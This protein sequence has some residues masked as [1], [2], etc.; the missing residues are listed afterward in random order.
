MW[1]SIRFFP[2]DYTNMVLAPCHKG[3]QGKSG[4][5]T[6]ETSKKME[7]NASQS[8]IAES[9]LTSDDLDIWKLPDTGREKNN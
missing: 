2:S 1:Y 6:A 3:N 9:K 8:V 5:K 7:A 4:A